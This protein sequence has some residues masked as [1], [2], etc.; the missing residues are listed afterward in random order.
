MAPPRAVMEDYSAKVLRDSHELMRC[1]D[2]KRTIRFREYG[3]RVA[4]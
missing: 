2:E 4:R 1:H 3:T